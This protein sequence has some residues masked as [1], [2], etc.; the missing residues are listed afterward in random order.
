MTKAV[1]FRLADELVD[2]LKRDS[3]ATGVPQAGIVSKALR[4]YLG[5]LVE[6]EK[7]K[8]V[9]TPEPQRCFRCKTVFEGRT[10]PACGWAA[11]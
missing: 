4:H 5:S 2:A 7:E 9:V 6:E 3:Q 8:K 10:C 11:R 1:T